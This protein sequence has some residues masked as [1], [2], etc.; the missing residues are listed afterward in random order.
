ME[1]YKDVDNILN[2]ELNKFKAQ[3]VKNLYSA[4][5]VVTGSFMRSLRVNVGGETGK[6]T[7]A[8]YFSTV[9]TG[10]SP[11]KRQY[12]SAPKFFAEIIEAWISK[13]G[14]SLNPYAVAT[15]IMRKG[16]KLYREGGREDIYSNEIPKTIEDIK[17]R[18]GTL[19]R[20]EI[21][22]SINNITN[23]V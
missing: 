22:N 13:K 18:L 17:A 3:V 6:V 1:V 20:L 19:Y 9:E 12:K 4:R 15:T 7:A 8:P 23:N 16:S 21:V 5:K 11:W 10:S 2:E 14:L